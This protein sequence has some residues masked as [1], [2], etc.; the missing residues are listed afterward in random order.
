MALLTG[1]YSG[2]PESTFDFDI[3]QVQSKGFDEFANAVIEAEL[4]EAFWKDLLPQYLDTSSTNNPYFRL[5]LAAQVKMHDHGFLSRDITVRD[6]ILN[7]SDVHHVY[8]RNFLKSQGLP[9]GRYNQIANYVL[10]QSE[11]NIA[12]GDKSPV[13]YFQHLVEQCDSSNWAKRNPRKTNTSSVSTTSRWRDSR[14]P[15]ARRASDDVSRR[16]IDSAMQRDPHR[17]RAWDPKCA[18]ASTGDPRCSCVEMSG[19]SEVVMS[20]RNRTPSKG[21]V[22]KC[23]RSEVY[24]E[25]IDPRRDE[26]LTII[27]PGLKKVSLSELERKTGVCR[28]A[29]S[30]LRAGR[31]RPHAKNQRNESMHLFSFFPPSTEA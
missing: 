10:A 6:L 14:P 19:S 25:Y 27:R 28:R 1:G 13:V 17:D 18:V 2:S 12:I 20:T 9:R 4:S 30:D 11:I 8:P 22:W 5:V 15:T 7:R 3:R 31:S 26:W 24:A 16:S 29:L 21:R 23:S